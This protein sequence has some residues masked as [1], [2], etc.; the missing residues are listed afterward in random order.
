MDHHLFTREAWKAE[1]IIN[2][3]FL[4]TT[5]PIYEAKFPRIS[6]VS[7]RFEKVLTIL[8][9]TTHIK[10]LYLVTVK[11]TKTTSIYILE[12]GQVDPFFF[13]L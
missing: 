1:K 8:E 4:T 7:V 12:A 3:L 9:L 11:G 2:F 5:K 13:F 10:P 6:D